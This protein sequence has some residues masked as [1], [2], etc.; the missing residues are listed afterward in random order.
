MRR[1]VITVS[2]FY[3]LAHV[4]LAEPAAIDGTV[5][6]RSKSAMG[7]GYVRLK[8]A[9]AQVRDVLRVTRK[10][11][12]VGEVMIFEVDGL[13]AMVMPVAGK[14][15]D[16]RVGDG[17][18]LVGHDEANIQAGLTRSEAD[19]VMAGVRS[20]T[21]RI[22][23]PSSSRA[24]SSTWNPPDIQSSFVDFRPGQITTAVGRTGGGSAGGGQMVVSGAPGGTLGLS[25]GGNDR[26]MASS[27]SRAAS[28]RSASWS[29]TDVKSSFTN[30][31]PGQITDA[32]GRTVSAGVTQDTM[33][34]RQQFQSEGSATVDPAE[35]TMVSQVS[36]GQPALCRFCYKEGSRGVTVAS[37]RS[38]LCDSCLKAPVTD[39]TKVEYN[40]Y[41]FVTDVFERVMRWSTVGLKPNIA[42]EDTGEGLLG[43]WPVESS[44]FTPGANHFGVIKVKRGTPTLLMLGVIAHEWSHAW[45]NRTSGQRMGEYPYNTLLYQEGFATWAMAQF[46]DAV[47][48]G[49]YFERDVLPTLPLTPYRTGYQMFL[50]RKF[51]P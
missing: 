14:K 11:G 37:I 10:G 43:Y 28:G 27:P 34:V 26:G 50:D 51:K 36:S 8:L 49:A 20:R 19:Q 21:A 38:F 44:S 2:L 7:C 35:P 25:G 9:G 31:S 18:T 24:R 30:F 17:V 22:P 32:R 42:M 45:W 29:P 39:P 4:V 1:F 12:V 48:Q 33:A 6:A 5:V 15:V 40:L 23:V 16:L 3:L 41:P 13:Y 47:G 46:Y